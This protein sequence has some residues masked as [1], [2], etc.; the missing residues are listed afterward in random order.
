MKLG[1]GNA[2]ER[3]A[4]EPVEARLLVGLSVSEGAV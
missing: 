1:V 3:A 4:H 2:A